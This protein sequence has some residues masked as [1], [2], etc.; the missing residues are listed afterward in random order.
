MEKLNNDKPK[1]S[2][3]SKRQTAPFADLSDADRRILSALGDDALCAD[4]IAEM[5]DLAIP[6]LMQRLTIL[7]IRGFITALAGDRFSSNIN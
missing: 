7:E 4:Q 6:E 5:A 1:K 2:Q 3:A